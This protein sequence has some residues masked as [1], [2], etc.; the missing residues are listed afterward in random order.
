MQRLK[1]E[2]LTL[3]AVGDEAGLTP[4]AIVQRFGSKRELLRALNARFAGG[5]AQ[6]LAALRAGCATPLAAIRAYAA[7]VASMGATPDALAHH[8]AYLQ[9]DLSDPEMFA[10]VREH[11]RATRAAIRTW[12]KEALAAGE[13]RAG[14]DPTYLA[15]I[16]HTTITGSMMHYVFFRHGSPRAWVLKDLALALEPYT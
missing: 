2:E 1:P 6:M 5:T 4:A 10:Q 16:I 13:L 8:L 7:Q 14:A 9:V 15:R 12:V 3:A 11:T